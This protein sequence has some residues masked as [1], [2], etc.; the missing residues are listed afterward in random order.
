MPERHARRSKVY[1]RSCPPAGEFRPP[2]VRERPDMR[3][4]SVP[5]R[6]G[7]H[8]YDMRATL[9]LA[10]LIILCAGLLPAQSGGTVTGTVT[11]ESSGEPMHAARIVLS[12]LGKH[13]D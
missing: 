5:G 9:I 3:N 6:W 11:L 10:V 13:V 8:N 7:A 12:P 2:T 4:L 1:P